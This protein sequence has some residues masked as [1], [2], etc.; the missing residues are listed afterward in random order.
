MPRAKFEQNDFGAHGDDEI[1]L[2]DQRSAGQVRAFGLAL[3]GPNG[4]GHGAHGLDIIGR[5]HKPRPHAEEIEAQLGVAIEI[6]RN[7][8]LDERGAEA[9]AR[10][11]LHG[12]P[13][14]LRPFDDQAAPLIEAPRHLHL[15]GRIGER[16]V[17][18]RI[19]HHLMDDE[20]QG[21]EGLGIERDIGPTHVDATGA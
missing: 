19:G 5:H 13:A 18:R 1:V 12:R 10:R 6:E 15:P 8:P 9:A 20:C 16:A 3:V 7:R 14:A 21:G 17:F 2:D 11:R 4:F